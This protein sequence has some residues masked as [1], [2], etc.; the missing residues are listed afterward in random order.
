MPHGF[1][2]DDR[3]F[4]KHIDNEVRMEI[5]PPPW[6]VLFYSF[7]QCLAGNQIIVHG[8]FLQISWLLRSGSKGNAQFFQIGVVGVCDVEVDDLVRCDFASAMGTVCVLLQRGYQDA[9]N[10]K[11]VLLRRLYFAENELVAGFTIGEVCISC[12]HMTSIRFAAMIL[13]AAS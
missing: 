5:L 11:G 4:F 10:G 12:N 2:F 8:L 1:S 7:Q 3:S 13:S 6:R 9:A